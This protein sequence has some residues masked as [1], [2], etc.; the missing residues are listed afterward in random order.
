MFAQK[1]GYEENELK[2]EGAAKLSKTAFFSQIWLVPKFDSD[3]LKDLLCELLITIQE[4]DALR[5][6]RNKLFRAASRDGLA[7]LS[8]S[9]SNDTISSL[10]SSEFSG[11]ETDSSTTDTETPSESDGS[12]DIHRR[13]QSRLQPVLSMLTA[14]EASMY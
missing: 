9:T 1:I 6:F 14:E 3:Q 12:M 4:E 8:R 11:S 5:S 13:G 10:L 2:V 7:A